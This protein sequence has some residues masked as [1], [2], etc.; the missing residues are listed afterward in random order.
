LPG[1]STPSPTARR[2]TSTEASRLLKL[3]GFAGIAVFI[4]VALWRYY[5]PGRGGARPVPYVDLTARLGEITFVRPVISII[6]KQGK[7]D[8]ILQEQM[9]G[10]GAAPRVDYRSRQAV[11]VALGPRSS[12]GYSLGI[13]RVTEDRRRVLVLVREHA[14]SLGAR[15]EPRITYPYRL[16]TLERTDKRVNVHFAGR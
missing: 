13:V 5:V 4:G 10:T 3:A 14:P 6:R 2:S 15:V 9:P 7:L 12:T 1:S 16:I 8:E 11:L